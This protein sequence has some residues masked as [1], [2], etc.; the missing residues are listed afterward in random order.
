M[1][2]TALRALLAPFGKVQIIQKEMWTKMYRYP[3]LNG[4]C[5][6]TI[7]LAKHISSHLTV[8][9]NRVLLSYEG[10]PS[11]CYVCGETGHVLQTCPKRRHKGNATATLQREL[12]AAIAAQI[13]PSPEHPA[14]TETP[15]I[16]MTAT[17][18]NTEHVPLTMTHIDTESNDIMMGEYSN[19]TPV[20]T[21]TTTNT[22][23]KREKKP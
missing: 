9:E 22:T 17:Y 11:T 20:V 4:I 14:T 8:A 2:D 1:P 5:Q 23:D 12:Y 18:D 6:V 15:E 16:Q 10:Q 19:P 21:Q 13:E 7:M 3:V